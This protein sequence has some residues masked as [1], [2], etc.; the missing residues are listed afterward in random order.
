MNYT[1]KQL[2][3]LAGVSVRT[4]HHYDEIGL[5][6]PAG[7][8]ANG[9]RRYD[10]SSV[11]RLQSI[12]LY[13][14]LDFPLEAIRA[15]LDRPDH[16]PLRAL[17]EQR[18][19]LERR[20]GRLHRLITTLDATILHLERHTP[21]DTKKMFEHLTPQQE[22]AYTA[23]AA[24]RWDPATVKSSQQRWKRY[25]DARRKEIL[26]EGNAI[27][28]DLA[29]ILTLD[30]ASVPVQACVERWRAHLAHFWTPND[31]QCLGLAR[32]YIEDPGF[33][34]TFDRFDPRLAEFMQR[35]VAIHVAAR[36]G[37]G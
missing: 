32:T 13:R 27:Y 14:E 5:L 17:R 11:L 18:V 28:R 2:A 10:Q 33:R 16:D 31:E 30:P 23:E 24:R 12:L 36:R 34:A 6:P 25:S 4:L 20:R 21:M 8:G 29:A 15:L 19:A 7:I 1:V 22:E 35:A 9:Y 37:A 26:E 3:A